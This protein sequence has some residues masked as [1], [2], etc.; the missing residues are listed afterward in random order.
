MA[1][2]FDPS[3]HPHRRRNPLT[4]DWVVVSPQRTKRPWQGQ[5]DDGAGDDTP[6]Y[7][8]GCYL[9]PGNARAGGVTNPAYTS[10]FVFEND[11]AALLPGVPAPS[12]DDIRRVVRDRR[13]RRRVPC[14]L[15]LAAPR[16]D[17]GEDVARRDRRRDRALARPVRRAERDVGV[18][19]AVRDPW[20]DLRRIEPSPS[21]SDLVVDVPA[22]RSRVR[23]RVPGCLPRA[24]RHA[25][26]DRLRRA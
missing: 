9:C 2:Q 10:T 25:D 18:G 14:H 21:R 22:Q 5:T 20:R 19:P 8:S 26:A 3:V 6:S 24:P 1:E 4:G 12:N 15:L 23:D 17:A 16:P 11:F 7:D 13:R